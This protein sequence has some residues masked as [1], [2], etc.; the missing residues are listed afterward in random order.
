MLCTTLS[1]YSNNV[2]K[3]DPPLSDPTG[4]SLLAVDKG[5]NLIK[6]HVEDT[7]HIDWIHLGFCSVEHTSPQRHVEA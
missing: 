4:V 7:Y 2:F 6:L 1:L 5:T 3:R